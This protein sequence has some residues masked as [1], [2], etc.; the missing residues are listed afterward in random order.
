MW[1]QPSAAAVPSSVPTAGPASGT[2][3]AATAYT[4]QAQ[5]FA[6]AAENVP[7]PAVPAV[8]GISDRQV[9]LLGCCCAS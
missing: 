5:A 8:V 1:N 3:P 9:G 2:L 7:R 6:A 4:L